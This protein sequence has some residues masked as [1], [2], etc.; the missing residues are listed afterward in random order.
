MSSHI[1]HSVAADYVQQANDAD[2]PTAVAAAAPRSRHRW[3]KMNPMPSGAR[4]DT[5]APYC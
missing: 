5:P 4:Q 2:L 1:E 3:H